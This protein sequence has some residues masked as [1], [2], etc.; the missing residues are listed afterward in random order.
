MSRNRMSVKSSQ[1]AICT[2]HEERVEVRIKDIS[3]FGPNSRWKLVRGNL[4]G[5]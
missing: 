4:S 2:H 1:D 3:T 5:S